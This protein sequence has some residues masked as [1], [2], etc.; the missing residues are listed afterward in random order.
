LNIKKHNIFCSFSLLLLIFN[1]VAIAQTANKKFTVVIDAG[2]G[3]NDPGC[4][5]TKY[6]EKDVALAVTLKLGKYIEENCSDVKVVYTRKTDV[7]IELNERAKI[8]N[9]NYADLFICIH[10]NASPNKKVFGSETYVMGLHK[11][12]GN[13]DVAKRENSAILLENNYKK[14]YENFDPN[15]DEGNIIFTMYQNA[16]LE[17]SLSLADK[18]QTYYKNKSCRTDKGVK[19]AG[20]LVLWKTSMPSL[21]TETG[22]LTNVEEEKFLG[23]KQGQDYL[24]TSI[25]LA[26]RKYKDELK[27]QKNKY[28]DELENKKPCNGNFAIAEPYEYKN[29]STLIEKPPDIKGVDA[30]NQLIKSDTIKKVESVLNTIV[31]EEMELPLKVTSETV[32]TTIKFRVQFYNSMEK[33]SKKY[34]KF[35]GINNIT[36]IKFGNEYKYFA[37]DFSNFD[38]ALK[39]QTLI[40]KKGFKD[41]FV[42]AFD[43][44]K[45]ITVKEALEKIKK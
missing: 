35:N 14:N 7:F 31:M 37:G 13:L 15:S 2:H 18:I 36:E 38:V 41:A 17:Q 3:G 1:G 42:V 19:Q 45:K 6:K 10:C 12:K 5:G 32:K 8:A 40:R 20:F 27:G 25:F 28:F 44:T 9:D 24:A 16:N 21:L 39:E 29:D 4:H 34:P 23:S 26:F 33:L 22:F 30:T 43:G 11:T